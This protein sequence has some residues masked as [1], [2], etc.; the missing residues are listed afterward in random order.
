MNNKI[1]LIVAALIGAA[2]MTMVATH[3][4]THS[5]GVVTVQSADAPQESTTTTAQ[6]IPTTT[7]TTMGT[8]PVEGTT[9]T[10]QA[11]AATTTTVHVTT[12]TQPHVVSTTS[13]TM[14]PTS[15]TVTTRLQVGPP[16][17][18]RC[19][20]PLDSDKQGELSWNPRIMP[21]AILGSWKLEAEVYNIGENLI[22]SETRTARVTFGDGSTKD[23]ELVPDKADYCPREGRYWDFQ[24]EQP[25]GQTDK[26]TAQ[27]L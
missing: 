5:S 24:L 16:N 10:T 23:F 1:K 19:R 6:E 27:I 20:V 15:T 14:V 2:A 12:T 17:T 4:P 8:L 11:P 25:E 22:P 21:G 3:L 7:S 13:T 9:S 26:P 18:N